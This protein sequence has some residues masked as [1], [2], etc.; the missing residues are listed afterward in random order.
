MDSK[1][2]KKMVVGLLFFL[3][4]FVATKEVNADVFVQGM[5]LSEEEFQQLLET[6][7]EGHRLV[8]NEEFEELLMS[9]SSSGLF[10]QAHIQS[11]G[12]QPQRHFSTAAG[13]VGRGLRLE[14]LQLRMLNANTNISYRFHIQ[15]RGW[16]T[17]KSNGQTAGTVGQGLRT[18]AIQ[19]R[20]TGQFGVNYRAHVQGHGWLPWVSSGG[21]S[22][23]G[24]FAGTTGQ[25]RRL[26]AIAFALYVQQV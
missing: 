10:H 13:S 19:I 16:E 21:T 26:E 12:W 11:F 9:R 6:V 1:K 3:G 8:T 24:H 22:L 14:D 18:E 15:S 20:T 2:L 23:A 7:P 17:W 4:L 25:A 5:H